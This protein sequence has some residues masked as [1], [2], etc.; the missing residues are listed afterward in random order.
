M[1]ARKD[2]EHSF[3]KKGLRKKSQE[4][5]SGTQVSREIAK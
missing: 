1:L 4:K 5:G 3:Q 2:Q